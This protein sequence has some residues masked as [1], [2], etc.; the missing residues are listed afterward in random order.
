MNYKTYKEISDTIFSKIKQENILFWD[1][2]CINF[3]FEKIDINE[4]ED[5]YFV[6][7]YNNLERCI[8]L[9]WEINDNKKEYIL[10]SDNVYCKNVLNIDEEKF[11]DLDSTIIS[12]VAMKEV[13]LAVESILLN[14]QDN[15]ILQ[16]EASEV[17]INLIDVIIEG[18]NITGEEM[19]EEF[20][21]EANAQ[22]KL[23]KELSEKVTNYTYK[24]RN[25][26]R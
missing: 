17:P 1:L 14:Y 8:A 16:Y 9:L 24:D 4:F 25:I 18:I 2:W 21:N 6:E 19:N 15:G 5:E 7:Y 10:L 12:D 11:E 26:Y 13:L 20:I 22:I 3:A 23:S